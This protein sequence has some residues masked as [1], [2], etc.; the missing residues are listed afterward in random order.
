MKP[1]KCVER[2]Q[3]TSK[4]HTQRDEIRKVVQEIKEDFSK[5][6]EV[7]NVNKSKIQKVN[8]MGQVN[9]L[10]GKSHQ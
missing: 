1:K 10:C 2:K 7:L 4:V 9:K 8:I 5:E 6:T 3:S